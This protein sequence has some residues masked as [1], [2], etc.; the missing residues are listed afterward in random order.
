[1]GDLSEH[2][3]SRPARIIF[4]LPKVVHSTFKVMQDMM[5]SHKSACLHVFEQ[6][7]SFFGVWV[8]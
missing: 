8:T 1:M 6:G 5:E 4:F 3:H 7:D 2:K